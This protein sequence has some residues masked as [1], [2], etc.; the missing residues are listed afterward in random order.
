MATFRKI[1]TVF[2]SD[3]FVQSLS[4]ERKYFFLYLL[5]NEKT[6]QCGIYEI[7]KH[8]M[9]YD[10]GYNIDTVSIL[11]KYFIETK[12]IAYSSQT[13]E[14]AIK[15]WKKYNDNASPKVQKLV[16][17]ELKKVKNKDL[18]LYIDTIDTVSIRYPQQEEER[19]QEQEK[20]K[21]KKENEKNEN[22]IFDIEIYLK[23]NQEDF[24]GICR[25]TSL[26]NGQVKKII[27]KFHLHQIENNLYPKLPLQLIAG[28]KKWILNEKNISNGKETSRTSTT[29][30]HTEIKPDGSFGQL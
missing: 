6:R 13:N 10:T 5:T 21:K 12:K 29:S 1:H 3:P 17:D 27:Q 11:L 30:G 22:L 8:Q 26:G 23:E 19:E 25:G 2:W 7:A 4:P 20:N 15:N 9:A 18:I 24:Y 14:I 28:I 16:N